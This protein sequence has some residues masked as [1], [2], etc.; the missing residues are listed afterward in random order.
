MVTGLLGIGRW[1]QERGGEATPS[2]VATVEASLFMLLTVLAL[3]RHHFGLG[4]AELLDRCIAGGFAAL[5]THRLWWLVRARVP[6]EGP[7]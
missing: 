6:V 3:S 1:A 2:P 7:S 4:P 5:L